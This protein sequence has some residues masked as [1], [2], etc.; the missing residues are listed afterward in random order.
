M[1]LITEGLLA[2]EQVTGTVQRQAA[3]LLWR[4]GR[5][6]PHV[7]PGD[8]FADRLGINGIVLVPLYIGLY[9]G[10]W[11]QANSVTKRLEFARPVMR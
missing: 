6:K 11:H 3:L 9:V 1:A 8:R 4:L 7:G 2:D 5:D 10:R